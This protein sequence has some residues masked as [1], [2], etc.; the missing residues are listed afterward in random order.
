MQDMEARQGKRAV[1]V[2]TPKF[3]CVSTE[4]GRGLLMWDPQGIVR[5]LALD[6]PDAALGSAVREALERSRFLTTQEA[7]AFFGRRR[8]DED[9]EAWARSLMTEFGYR[10]RNVLFERMKSCDVRMVAGA[11]AFE[12]SRHVGLEEWEGLAPSET[13][14]LEADASAEAVGAAA[15]T[16]LGRCIE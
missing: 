14:T 11:L 9:W 7:K 3:I 15:R 8:G 1:I 5:T 4:S 2:Q 12:P 6:A 13:V 16:A 10:S